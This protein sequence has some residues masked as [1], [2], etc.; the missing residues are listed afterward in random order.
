MRRFVVTVVTALVVFAAAGCVSPYV[1]P[2]GNA[3]LRYRDEVFTT[4]DKTSNVVYGSAL[5]SQGQTEQLKLDVYQ[6]SGDTVTHRPAIVWVHGGSFSSGDK[7]SAELVDEANTFAK[8]G[9]VNVSINYRLM[10]GGCAASSPTANCVTAIIDAKHDA[11]AAVRFLRANADTYHVDVDRIA[12]GGT[13]AGAITALNVGYDP[14]E[15]GNSGNPGY[16]SNVSAA[17][18][19]SG[20]RL[21]GAPDAGDAPSLLFHGTADPL[22]PY[23]WATSTVDGAHNASLVSYLTTWDG[24]GHV[25]Y[26]QHR[27]EIIDQTTNFLYWTLRLI[28]PPT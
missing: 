12:I 15:V 25:P 26:V 7:T 11:Q 16:S 27:T 3:P 8:K 18:S 28:T 6:P 10:P 14:T 22:V 20:A 23:A 4:V 5:N 19:L 2:P 13:S 9:Y 1:A 21:L 24:A 17:V